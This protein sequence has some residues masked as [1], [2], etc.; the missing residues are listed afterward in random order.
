MRLADFTAPG[1]LTDPP[2]SEFVTPGDPVTAGALGYL[3]ANCGHCHN[4]LGAAS[5]VGMTLRL[6]V[7]DLPPEATGTWLTT[8]AVPTT[9]FEVGGVSFRLLPASPA[10][11]A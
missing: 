5:Y 10:S 6:S 2:A 9:L 3:H 11:H 1:L 4:P 8:V 7:A